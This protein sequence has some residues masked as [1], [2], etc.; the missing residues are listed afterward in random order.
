M[1]VTASEYGGTIR[2][3]IRNGD[4]NA[5]SISSYSNS[6]SEDKLVTWVESHDNY[7]G[8][9]SWRE[10]NEQQVKLGWAIITARSGGTP[11]FFSRPAGA[12]LDDQWGNNEIGKKGSDLFKD[13]EV[14]AV[15]RFRNVMAGLGETLSN[16]MDNEE[17]VMIERGDKGAV[18]I[19]VSGKDAALKD[20]T[21]VL[22]DGSYKEKLTDTEFTVAGGK[23]S[24][25]VGAGQVAVIY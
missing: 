11:L 1:H 20:V 24:G 21:T 17:L 13:K 5:N 18:I 15:N 8:D 19:N 9:G 14:A 6:A 4:L 10:L 3:A 7:C 2:N 16:P 23:L 22:A 25:T 12:N